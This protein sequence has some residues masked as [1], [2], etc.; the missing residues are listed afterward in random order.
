MVTRILISTF[1]AASIALAACGGGDSAPKGPDAEGN[2][3]PTVEEL[4]AACINAND[5][6]R[7]AYIRDAYCECIA[8]EFHDAGYTLYDYAKFNEE[9]EPD[10]VAKID[11]ACL[12]SA[13]D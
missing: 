12:E 8:T 10:D 4:K 5:Y 1:A 13:D 6:F 7:A 3:I 9:G 11:I 2:R